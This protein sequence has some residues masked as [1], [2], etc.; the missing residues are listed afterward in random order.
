MSHIDLPNMNWVRS[1]VKP[2]WALC[3]D[4][5]ADFFGWKMYECN[6]NWVS[7]EKLTLNEVQTCLSRTPDDLIPHIARLVDL[8]EKLQH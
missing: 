8:K 3:L 4:P 7:S 6:G 1:P 2:D 5:E